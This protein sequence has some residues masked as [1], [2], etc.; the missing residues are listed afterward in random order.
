MHHSLSLVAAHVFMSNTF[1]ETQC[2]GD[3]ELFH[4]ST[5][6]PGRCSKFRDLSKHV[7]KSRL[8]FNHDGGSDGRNVLAILTQKP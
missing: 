1:L 2:L 3:H 7:L 6:I 5:A 4:I 8:S